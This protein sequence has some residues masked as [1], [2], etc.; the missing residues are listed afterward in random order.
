M[1]STN[2]TINKN[3]ISILGA[4]SSG[5]AFASFGVYQQTPVGLSKLFIGPLV[6]NNISTEPHRKALIAKLFFRHMLSLTDSPFI[7]FTDIMATV[8]AY[9]DINMGSAERETKTA[10]QSI[11]RSFFKYKI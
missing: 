5:S 4:G 3:K 6:P 1:T 11:S 7:S 2:T 8:A 10:A 9:F